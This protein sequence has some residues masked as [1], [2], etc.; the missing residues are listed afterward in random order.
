MTTKERET[1]YGH[2]QEFGRALREL[3]ETIKSSWGI[4]TKRAAIEEQKPFHLSEIAV[5]IDLNQTIQR[6]V[7]ALG[8]ELDSRKRTKRLTYTKSRSQQKNMRKWGQ[9]R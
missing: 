8:K 7:S 4:R 3:W 1:F 9:K 6:L 5:K 2:M